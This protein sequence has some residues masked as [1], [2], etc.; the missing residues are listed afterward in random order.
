MNKRKPISLIFVMSLA[1]II[2]Q[3]CVTID[4]TKGVCLADNKGQRIFANAIEEKS[5]KHHSYVQLVNAQNILLLPAKIHTL[6]L[7]SDVPKDGCFKIPFILSDAEGGYHW[8][9]A[10]GEVLYDVYWFDNGPDYPQD[11][12]FRFKRNGL[13]GY[14]D[15]STYEV[16]IPARYQAAQPFQDGRAKVSYKAD[17]KQ[18]DDEHSGWINTDYFNINRQGD[19]IESTID[20]KD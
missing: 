4:T 9:N 19:A 5:E 2:I 6:S 8:F 11:G 15:E 10:N 20:V 14:V 7:F 13:I 12:L 18:L 16:V 1:F 3:G 17:V